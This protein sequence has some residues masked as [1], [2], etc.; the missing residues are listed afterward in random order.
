M[1]SPQNQTTPKHEDWIA[2]C[3]IMAGSS[4]GR[5]DNAFEAIANCKQAVER[6]WVKDGGYRFDGPVSI[7]VYDV[8]GHDDFTW[9]RSRQI[10]SSDGAKIEPLYW[11]HTKLKQPKSKKKK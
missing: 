4:H 1:K 5:A 9:H 2:I 11:V 8:S 10:E 3:F 7:E 6:D